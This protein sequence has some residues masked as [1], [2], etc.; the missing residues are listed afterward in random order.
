MQPC[1]GFVTKRVIQYACKQKQ[2]KK[3]NA[4]TQICGKSEQ[5]NAF[6][7]DPAEQEERAEMRQQDIIGFIYRRFYH[8]RYGKDGKHDQ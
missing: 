2:S 4:E 7:A 5:R 6:H 1:D 3:K 8:G